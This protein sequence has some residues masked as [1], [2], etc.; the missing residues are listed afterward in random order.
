MIRAAHVVLDYFFTSYHRRLLKRTKTNTVSNCVMFLYAPCESNLT[1]D[2]FDKKE[3]TDDYHNLDSFVVPFGEPID[4]L[5]IYIK[6][7][8]GK[9]SIILKCNDSHLSVDHRNLAYRAAGA[10][11]AHLDKPFLIK[12][13]LYKRIPAEAGLGGGSIDAAV[14]LCAFNTYF[15]QAIDRTIL[16]AIAA[17]LGSSV[18]LFLGYLSLDTSQTIFFNSNYFHSG[19]PLHT[20]NNCIQKYDQC[21]GLYI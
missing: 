15:N 8:I 12:I 11:L 4:E 17:H 10:Y 19:Q 6:P 16:M 21:I 5:R 3:R 18:S 7:V 14:V 13:D 2:V 20:Y 1:L 9:A